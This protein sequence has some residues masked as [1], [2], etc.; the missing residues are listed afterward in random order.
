M[1]ALEGRAWLPP[2][3]LVHLFAQILCSKHT[4][5]SSEQ[6]PEQWLTQRHV[7]ACHMPGQGSACAQSVAHNDLGPGVV[8]MG[9]PQPGLQV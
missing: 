9:N 7:G 4:R 5:S 1:S 3:S 2:P 8:A 6:G